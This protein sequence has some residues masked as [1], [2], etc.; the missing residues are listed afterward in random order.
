ME[1]L[2]ISRS[3]VKPL[4]AW[5]MEKL[6]RLKLN[7]RV[8]SYSPLSRVL[9]LESLTI[10]ITGKIRLWTALEQALG[11]TLGEVDFGALA[12]RAVAQ[13]SR[14]EELHGVAVARALS[15]AAPGAPRSS[16]P[17]S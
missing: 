2:R 17:R 4:G 16:A 15:S 7:G 3:P 8:R 14:I 6:G 12:E 11:G 1:R 13:R 9:E 5:V 10:G